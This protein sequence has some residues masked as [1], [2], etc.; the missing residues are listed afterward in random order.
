MKSIDEILDMSRSTGD[1]INDLKDKR[2][3]VPSWSSLRTDYLPEHHFILKDQ[4]GSRD[5]LRKAG[6][7]EEAARI[8]LG[9]EKM[10]VTRMS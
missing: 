5:T 7:R 4:E 1:I 9:L 6:T 10:L 3:S 8:A 2:V